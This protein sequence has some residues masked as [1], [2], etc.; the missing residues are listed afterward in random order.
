MKLRVQVPNDQGKRVDVNEFREGEHYEILGKQKIKLLRH[1]WFL[2][3]G[4]WIFINSGFIY[5]GASIPKIFWF[6]IGEP[7]EQ[8][9]ALASLIHDYL[10]MMRAD[11]SQ[12]DSA[13]R[14]LLDD[15]GVNGRRVALMFWAV[16]AGGWWFYL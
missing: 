1:V 7:T 16:R 4:N 13:F 12:A 9:F 10:Y 11:R 6:V 15:A 5:N 14:D 3:N 8:K 2:W